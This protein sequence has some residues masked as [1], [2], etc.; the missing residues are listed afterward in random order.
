[1]TLFHYLA[2]VGR[3]KS[4]SRRR[5][6]MA[7]FTATTAMLCAATLTMHG[8]ALAQEPDPNGDPQTFVEQVADRMLRV[9]KSDSRLQSGDIAR[10]NEA[11]DEY[12][13]PYVDFEKTTRLAAGRYWREATPKQRQ[14]L[15]DAFR[16]TLVRTYAG[17]FRQVNPDTRIEMLP[18][19]GDPKAND[20][21]VRSRVIP[22][23]GAQP[24]AVEYRLERT[25]KG[26]RVYDLSVEGIWLIQNYRNQFATQIQQSGIDGLIAALNARNQ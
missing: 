2:R 18:F 26:W 17:A 8:R 23:Q 15:I 22:G 24:A 19:R 9:L 7:F 14:A 21:V 3:S 13:M 20:V 5:F 25:P 6:C 4:L 10:I 12:V 16:G 11:V 1:M